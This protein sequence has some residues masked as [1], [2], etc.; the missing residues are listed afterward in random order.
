MGGHENRA[1]HHVNTCPL[2]DNLYDLTYLSSSTYVQ[3]ELNCIKPTIEEILFK[4]G[5]SLNFV[6]H[7]L[8]SFGGQTDYKS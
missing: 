3:K 8:E 6:E 5:I 2:Y 1:G 4:F 7:Q